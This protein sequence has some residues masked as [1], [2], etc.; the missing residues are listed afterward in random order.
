MKYDLILIDGMHL[1]HR[2]AHSYANLGVWK[3]ED[4]IPTGSIYGFLRLGVKLW[5]KYATPHS[6]L[7]VCWDAGYDHRVALY[8]GYKENRR[9]AKEEGG[10][11]PFTPSQRTALMSLL[12]VAGW[13]QASSPGYE[14]DDVMA[15][16]ASQAPGTVAIYTGDQDLHQTVTDR[17][18]VL[19]SLKGKDVIWDI[20]KVREKWG[21]EPSRIPQAKGLAG[22]SSDNIPGCPGCGL[23]WAKKLLNRY[24]TLD[25][26]IEVASL[27]DLSG[28]YQGKAWKSPSLTVKVRENAHLIK[29]SYELAKIVHCPVHIKVE[30][31]RPEALRKGLETLEFHSL[32]KE[33]ALQSI[34]S[35]GQ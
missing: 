26:I 34:L 27:R 10:N 3:G 11:I 8:P 17:V 12:Q 15:T 32:L 25:Q 29:V 22:D 7:V 13:A 24:D 5:D 6:R 18:H 19:S 35:A 28:F 23:G 30:E 4:F 20:D 33:K 9:I 31:G 1:L 2:A 21:V 14:A 16:L